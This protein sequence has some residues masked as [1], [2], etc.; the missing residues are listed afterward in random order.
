MINL[1]I[2]SVIVL[3][4]ASGYLFYKFDLQ[5]S[6]NFELTKLIFAHGYLM[7]ELKQKIENLE[8]ELKQKKENKEL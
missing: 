1:L 4:I 8:K 3:I 5:R 6:I 2:F 7:E